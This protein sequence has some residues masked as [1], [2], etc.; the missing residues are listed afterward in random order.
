MQYNADDTQIYT[1][2]NQDVWPVIIPKLEEC[3]HEIADWSSKNDLSINEGK[4][5]LLHI[6]SRFRTRSLLPTVT[7]NKS[8]LQPARCARNLGVIFDNQLTLK[9]HVNSICRASSFGLYKIGSIRRYLNQSTTEKLVHAF[10]MSRIDNCNSLLHGLSDLL[11]GKLQRIQNSAARL[12][13]RTRTYES[14]SPILH[15]LHWLPVKDRIIFKLLI[16]AYKC[17]HQLAPHYLQ[18]LIKEYQPSRPLRSS[19]RHLLTPFTVVTKSYGQR[20][21]QYSI[22]HLWNQLPSNIKECLS[23]DQFKSL[24]KSHLFVV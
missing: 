20:S 5:E 23:V 10:V 18:N 13:A 19:S 24:L 6:C 15:T 16:I 22:P 1:T 7:F 4:T 3:L 2:G 11:T 12:V 8:I 14:V 21:F 17:Q 9:D